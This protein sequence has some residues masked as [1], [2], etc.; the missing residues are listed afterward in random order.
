MPEYV[1]PFCFTKVDNNEPWY[2]CENISC[3]EPNKEHYAYAHAKPLETLNEH[4]WRTENY[5]H[6]FKGKSR[7]GV[8]NK[9]RIKTTKRVCHNCH[10]PLPARVDE[11]S[12]MIVSIVGPK[13][14]GKSH[15]IAV[16]IQEIKRLHSKFGWSFYQS[17]DEI[18]N[19]YKRFFYNPLYVDTPPHTLEVTR[20]GKSN[21]VVRK[22]LVFNLG[23]GADKDHKVITIVFF[24]TA[25]ED[26]GTQVDMEMYNRYIYNSAGIILLVNP[27]EFSQVQ[28]ETDLPY[29]RNISAGEVLN[30]I[31][32]TIKEKSAENYQHHKITIPIAITLSMSDILREMMGDASPL[33]QESFHN[34]VFDLRQFNSINEYVQVWIEVMDD[35]NDIIQ[36]SRVFTETAFFGASALGENPI[37][38]GE[39][40]FSPHP[41]HVADPLLWILWKNGVIDG[42]E[43]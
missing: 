23:K 8:C 42:R 39:L 6:F 32:N 2:Q 9:C 35:R 26:M 27:L 28:N 16:L 17:D 1:C 19:L 12:N 21:E 22:P 13:N 11:L 25:G 36:L 29:E 10:F 7:S 15:Y 3:I 30:R 33:F 38:N 40:P 24:D 14:T 41:L 5:Q 43:R 4:E 20:S 31:I 34:G 18:I 37:S